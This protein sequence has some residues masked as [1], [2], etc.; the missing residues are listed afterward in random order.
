MRMILF[1]LLAPLALL[2]RDS[3]AGYTFG[4]TVVN[5]VTGEP[6]KGARVT[7]A[8]IPQIDPATGMLLNPRGAAPRTAA[9]G[10]GGEYLFAGLP[11]G[12]Y[13]VDAQKPGFA[14][15]SAPARSEW[16]IP[17][18][19][20]IDLTAPV[21]GHIIRLPPLGVI[22]GK[23]ADQHGDPLGGVSVTLF[24]NDI[25]DG[26]RHASRGR[27]AVTDDRGQFRFWDLFPG[28]YFV[29]AMGRVGGTSTYVGDS[30]VRY[31][32]W[33]GFHP[34]YFGGARDMDS[35]TP[36]AVEAGAD[37]RADF[38]LPLEP[39]FKIR[40]TLENYA[41][42]EAVVFKLLEGD[43][44]VADSRVSLD[45]TTGK[46][47]IDAVPSGQYTLRVTQGERARGETTV[48]VK[49]G[50]VAG[51]SVVLAPAMTL[52][53][54]E[55]LI[56][57]S[58]ARPA[59]S[60][61]GGAGQDAAEVGGFCN[62]ALS[63]AAPAPD[64][65]SRTGRLELDGGFS[66]EGVFPGQY[67]LR[68]YCSNRYVV[69]IV[70]GSSDLLSNPL[71]TVQPGVPPPP[72]EIGMKPGGGRLHGKL[73][74][75]GAHPGTGVL[76]APAFAAST[77]PEFDNVVPV[78]ESPEQLEFEFTDLAPGD[79]LAYGFSSIQLAEYRNPAFLSALTGG[80]SVRIEDGKTTEVTL[81]SLVK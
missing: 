5:S 81:T 61:N 74:V 76:L 54:S 47:E 64:D 39:A 44:N 73:S 33:E 40:G 72:I 34:E 50:D 18:P 75:P 52:T 57:P 23:L 30:A 20:N 77:G 60:T 29:K 58:P 11:A 8:E 9:T 78:S 35:A 66:I 28:K 17:A 68:L 31:D 43:P 36:L 6:V 37:A 7:L 15:Y 67:R 38:T 79:Y 16:A 71:L 56:G 25:A 2:A 80:E 63:P 21:S 69:S 65:D 3:P 62:V 26:V 32:S 41:S 27:T 46:F 42:S 70:S 51:V 14:L 1:V 59:D 4:G 53:G 49:G 22:E 12:Q 55:R 48:T 10:P 19:D 13:R 24:T 45:G